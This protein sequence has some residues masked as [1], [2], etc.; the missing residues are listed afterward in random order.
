MA[1]Q[2]AGAVGL[3]VT[4]PDETTQLTVEAAVDDVCQHG[5]MSTSPMAAERGD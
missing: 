4:P 5:W 2:P 1:G 3:V